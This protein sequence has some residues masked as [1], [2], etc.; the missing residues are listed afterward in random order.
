M[1][2]SLVFAAAKI[3]EPMSIVS[4]LLGM[5]LGAIF[6]LLPGLGG[7][8]SMAVALPFS[9]GM[10]P[11]HAMFLF[12]GIMSSEG[13]GGAIPSIL[14]NTP[15]TAQNAAT[16][17]DG[18][19]MAKR[20]EG[21]RA[22]SIAAT[23]CLAGS[24][25]G[26][27][28]TLVLLPVVKPLVYSFGYP[29]F[30]WLTALGLI[31]IAVAAKGNMIKGLAGGGIGVL[32]SM[33]GYTEMFGAFRYTMGSDYLWDGISLVPFVTGLFALSELIIYASRGGSTASLVDTS[34]VNWSSQALQGVMDVVKRPMLTI[35][36]AIVGALVGVVPGLGGPVAS[37][38][39][40]TV[41]M[42]SSKNPEQFG[43]GSPEGVLACETAMDAKDGGA[44]LPT[45]AF[46][47][48]GSPDQAILL[49]GFI[50]HGL[51][52]GP[53]MIRD[54]MEI[55]YA[56]LL[57]IV[58]AQ[59]CL[60]FLGLLIAP[61]MARLSTVRNRIIAP[62]VL[63]LVFFG[64]YMGRTNIFDVGVALFAGL[65]GYFMRRC[66]FPLVTVVM[67]FILG[68]LAERAFLQSLQMSDGSYLVF[69]TRPISAGLALLLVAM[70][71]LPII[72]GSRN[73]AKRSIA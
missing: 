20:G 18:Y 64:A 4:L 73:K 48:P 8:L 56:L 26:V 41:A 55:V 1:F 58:F 71:V 15:G 68:P 13:F 45:V 29:E 50:L 70:L 24:I 43:K 51:Q 25:G 47:I 49:G 2:E 36:S 72:K 60:S 30:F 33:I 39:S 31:T 63:L 17:L 9:Y 61:W 16:C 6:G 53:L 23:S 44:L 40:Y 27:V 57:G 69:V 66:G 10:E 62:F 21:G 65:L 22:I 14:L 37:F 3:L 67:G 19:P 12:A 59:V 46:G 38:V 52:P 34:Q 7:I 28:V 54:H 35:R 42:R 11:M 5:S 32:I